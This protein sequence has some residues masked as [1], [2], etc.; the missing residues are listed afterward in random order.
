MLESK[1]RGAHKT[2]LIILRHLKKCPENIKDLA[3]KAISREIVLTKLKGEKK[4][5]LLVFI[6]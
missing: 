4:L 3:L 1:I 5:I 6:L 2:K